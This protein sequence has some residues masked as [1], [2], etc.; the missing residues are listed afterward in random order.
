MSKNVKVSMAVIA[1][2]SMLVW[3]FAISAEDIKKS[4][5]GQSLAKTSGTPTF[6]IL[7]INNYTSWIRSDASGNLSPHGDNQGI[8]PRGTSGNVIYTDGI[9][10]G[11]KAFT[12][13]G[14]TTAAPRQGIRVGGKAY[15]FGQKAGRVT[16]SGATAVAANPNDADVRIF[17][18]RRDYAAM[19]DDEV[20]RDAAESNEIPVS[21][22]TD[23]QIAAIKNQYDLDWKNWPVVN[24]APYIDRN[25]NGQYDA[26]PAFGTSFTVDSLIAQNRD[27]PGVA[28]SDPNSPADQVIWTVANDLDVAQALAL[29]GSEPLGLEAQYTIWGYK[30]TDALGNLYFKRIR[31]I[32]KG[33][34]EVDGVT[35]AKG[36]FYLDS[37]FVCQWS[38]IDLGNAGDDLAGCDS[39]LS[40]GFVYNGFANDNTYIKNSL[41]P[42]ASGYDF[43]AG[44]IV[45]APGDSAVFN[46]KRRYNVK[47]LGMSSFAYFSAGSPYSDPPNGQPAGYT[48]TSGGW[49]KLLRGYAGVGGFSTNDQPFASGTFAASKFPLSGDPTTGKGFIDGQGFSGSFVPGDR[50][51]LLNTGPFVM[52]PGDTQEIVVG[53]VAG[54][55]ADRFSSVAVMKFNDRFVQNTFDALFQVPRAPAAPNVKVAELNGEIVIEWGSDLQRVADTETKVN[56]PGSYKFEGYNVYQLPKRTSRLS[57]GKLVKVFD[58]PDDPT[59]VLDQQFDQKSGQILNIPVFFGSNSDITRYFTFSRDYIKDIDKIY[60]GQEYYI[61]V[62]AYSVATVPGFLPAA[63]ESTP[64]V[65]TARPKIPFGKV[66]QTMPGDTI[67]YVKTGTS[68]GIV[69]PIV[70]DPTASTGSTYEVRFADAGG[71]AT[72]WSLLDKTK[73][74]TITSG[75]ANQ[76]G[77]GN[78]KIYD[79]MFLKVEGPPPGMKDYDIP[80]GTRRVTFADAD[81]LGFEGFETTIGWESPA[82]YFNGIDNPVTA[83]MLKNVVL[84]WAQ[85]SARTTGTL[86][87]GFNPYGGW[88]VDATTDVNMSYAYRYVRS[89][90]AAAARPEFAPYITNPV[91]YGF[92]EYKKSVPLSAWDVEAT[93]PVRLAVGFLENNVAGGLV[94]GRYFPPSNGN[95]QNNAGSTGPREWLF[96][97]NK[98]YTAATA[99]A[100]LQVPILSN[101]L[102]VMWWVAFSRRS[103]NLWDEPTGTN[104]FRILANHV[105]T[106]QTVFTFT[107]PAPQTGDELVKKSANTVGVY[108]NPY[109]AFNPAETNRFN[110][111]V[112]FNNLPPRVKFRV[113]NLAGQLVRVMDKDDTSQFFRWDLFNQ[114]NIPVASGVYVVHIEMADIGVTKVLK[115]AVIQEQEVLDT[116]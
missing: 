14:K 18:I 17:R 3:S 83:A 90:N 2:L 58:T 104:E 74:K 48:N 34:V 49:W 115:V 85:A 20:K 43:L 8:F 60:N 15:G 30:R 111:F 77:D 109:Y 63:L 1:F 16:G 107:A 11:A 13:A 105:N 56:Q 37:M 39:T 54:L 22:V 66:Y 73:N 99:D 96:V 67:T 88:D 28:G 23:A 64:L 114:N 86:T 98:P 68:D 92:Q 71:G 25:K 29:F 91:S 32:N 6:Q 82:H 27:E 36:S 101:P 70:V 47:N 87:N 19:N 75:E 10:W 50:R 80:T 62:T 41:P 89:A 42:P 57:E 72:T 97:F 33:G 94:D 108:P 69:R 40:M 12:N 52:A 7:N 76:S 81:G 51:I 4:D 93:P 21:E 53:T 46:L 110:R 9:V 44:P 65:L 116:Y 102:P 79:G 113:F 100:T 31:L 59:V 55:G 61:A 78:Y 106:P 45:P 24:G 112:T 35:K 26:P 103:N 5:K 95:G 84:R 38:D